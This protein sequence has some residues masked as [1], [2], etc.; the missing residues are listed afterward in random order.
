MNACMSQRSADGVNVTGGGEKSSFMVQRGTEEQWRSESANRDDMFWSSLHTHEGLNW[1]CTETCR[2]SSGYLVDSP[3]GEH[4]S[5][6]NQQAVPLQQQAAE[7]R[8]AARQKHL[9]T[10]EAGLKEQFSIW[11]ENSRET[12]AWSFRHDREQT[13]HIAET[14]PPLGDVFCL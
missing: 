8:L 13:Q 12:L 1:E 4:D 7:G 3:W 2:C 9:S 6:Q 10:G 11:T 14:F 5:S